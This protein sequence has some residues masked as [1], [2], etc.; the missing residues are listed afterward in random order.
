[1]YRSIRSVS[2]HIDPRETT[3]LI[4]IYGYI[5][6]VLH[7]IAI[8]NVANY[9][10]D[11]DLKISEGASTEWR[12]S[13]FAR[14]RSKPPGRLITRGSSFRVGQQKAVI[15]KHKHLGHGVERAKGAPEGPRGD[16]LPGN[17]VSFL[18]F[19]PSLLSL[20]SF[21]SF[22]FTAHSAPCFPSLRCTHRV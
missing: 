16:L 14:G 15:A 5:R 12:A 21:F 22:N 2:G 18:H 17:Y 19:L 6:G 8:Y 4:C 1:M 13:S 11:T 10:E 7:P 20:L 9:G 3:V